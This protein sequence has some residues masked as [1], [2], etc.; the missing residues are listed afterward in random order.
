MA[1]FVLT[2]DPDV[3]SGPAENN[4]FLFTP[5]TLQSTDTITGGDFV[6]LMELTAGGPVDALHSEV[7]T[8]IEQLNLSAAGNN[9]TL[10]DGL[11]SGSSAGFFTIVDGGGDDVV[12][13]S[14]LFSTIPLVFA[15]AAGSDTFTGGAGNDAFIFAAADLTSSDTVQ[16]GLG[17]DNLYF[18]TAGAVAPDAFTNV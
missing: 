8:N 3:F 5:T 12:D 17:I 14:A 1:T 2:S 15:A 9:I 16:G 7:V 18:S 13:G 6:D 10:T 4:T 11:V